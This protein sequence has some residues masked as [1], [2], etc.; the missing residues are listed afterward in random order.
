MRRLFALIVLLGSVL[1][2]ANTLQH[3]VVKGDA[4]LLTFSQ[5]FN[6]QAIHSFHLGRN[7]STRYV[8]DLRGVRL[9]SSRVPLGLHH[10]GV[11]SF[12]IS[13]YRPYTV[14][15]VIET[16]QA[17]GMSYGNRSEKV[18]AIR[19][20]HAGVRSLFATVG[21][22]AKRVTKPARSSRKHSAIQRPTSASKTHPVPVAV[23][24]P[25]H[26]YTVILDPGHG[27]HDTGAIGGHRREKDAVL[28]IA[29]VSC[30]P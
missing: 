4:L 29:P 26:R 28:Q 20:P 11:T 9:G 23:P 13:Q 24:L 5:Y 17:Y 19:L 12:R 27:G 16:Q 25:R 8:F 15:V 2:S 21:T 14:R 22:S 18:C 7:G 30:P 10:A 1:V 6:P 3:A